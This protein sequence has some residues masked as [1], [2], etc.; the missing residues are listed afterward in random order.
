[1]YASH[2]PLI[3]ALAGASLAC[4]LLLVLVI[5][6][7]LAPARAA[8]TLEVQVI[9]DASRREEAVKRLR[10]VVTPTH[11]EVDPIKGTVFP[12][13]DMGKMLRGLGEG[14][15]FDEIAPNTFL[16]N[17]RLL[18]QY[19]VMFL[20]CAPGGQE[21]R[22]LLVQFVSRGGTLYASDWR[23][24][25]VA[26][27]FPDYVNWGLAG[28][29]TRGEVL[30]E[31]VDPALRD[32]VGPTI[33]LRFDLPRWKTAA[34]GGPR[35]TTLIQGR[36]QKQ[37]FPQDRF[38]DPAVA[39]LLVRFGFG[40]GTVIFTSFHNEKQ[41]SELEKKLL[42]YL[43]FTLVT[44]DIDAQV[45]A[46]IQAAG[47]A[48]Q[49]SNLLSTPADNPAVTRTYTNGRP[50]PLRFALGFR[51]EGATLRLTLRSPEGKTFDWEGTSTVMLEV[52]HASPGEWTYTV[53]A[54]R[55]PYENFP[56]TVTVS[57]KK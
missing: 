5:D 39:P 14:Y 48:P 40:K 15:R 52:P 47:F 7:L 35:V 2:K 30:G 27:A 28:S 18:D 45:T 37:R 22:D 54:V 21:L 51:N 56:F 1:M 38:G 41:N 49:K 19:D 4:A 12:W 23:F 57:E 25:A 9:D 34:F 44:A 55:V 29:G 42:Q 33:P 13:D 24:E 31:V 16:G 3:D 20:T 26:A 53:T 43:V 46:K 50:G 10:L 8:N 17:P 36:Y 32:L 11:R 6:R